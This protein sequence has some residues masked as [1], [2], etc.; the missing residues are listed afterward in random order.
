MEN[1]ELAN[2]LSNAELDDNAKIDAIQKWLV[3]NT[4]QQMF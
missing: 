1:E 4:Y 2:V 3:P